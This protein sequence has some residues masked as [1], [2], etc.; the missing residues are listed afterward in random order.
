MK[1]KISLFVSLIMCMQ[2]LLGAIPVFAEGET[3]TEVYA[4]PDSPAVTYNMNLD[5]KFFDA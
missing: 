4:A 1:R 5:W 2:I 3:D